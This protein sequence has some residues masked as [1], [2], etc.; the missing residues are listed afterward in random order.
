MTFAAM[1]GV[2]LEKAEVKEGVVKAL[3]A[4]AGGMSTL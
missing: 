1:T 4:E 2:H 3:E